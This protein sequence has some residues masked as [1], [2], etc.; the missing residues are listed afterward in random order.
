M[1]KLM[2]SFLVLTLIFSCKKNENFGPQ[3][4]ENPTDSIEHVVNGVLVL[5]EGNFGFGNS[6][7]SVIDLQKDNIQNQIF[8]SFNNKVL[9]DIAQDVIVVDSIAFVV[10][11]NGNL[12]RAINLNDFKEIK[13]IKLTGSPRY[14]VKYKNELLVSSMGSNSIVAINLSDYS[15]NEKIVLSDWGW[16]EEM[17]I[18]NEK[19]YACNRTKNTIDVVNLLSIQVES[20]IK[21]GQDPESIIVDLQGNAWALCT[22]GFDKNDREKASIYKIN[23]GSKSSTLVYRFSDIENSPTRFR[24]SKSGNK[25]YFLNNGIFAFN[26]ENQGEPESFLS[27]SQGQLFYGLGINPINGNVFVTNAKD[28]ASNGEVIEIDTNSLVL[29]KYNAGIIPQAFSFY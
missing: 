4:L 23:N 6:S 8:K 1:K 2:L 25:A 9:G 5:N 19:L 11:N 13:E 18:H 20:Q 24:L 22:G 29:R 14:I 3:F 16:L 21:V 15:T 7:L 12:I 10:I 26:L 27:Q 28:Y 17:K